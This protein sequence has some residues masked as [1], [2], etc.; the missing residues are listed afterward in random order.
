SFCGGGTRYYIDC[1]Q[2]CCGPAIGGGF[3]AGCTPCGCA[4]GCNTRRVYCNYFRYG[5]CHQEIALTGPIACRVVSCVP[6]Y[7]F[8][9]N[10]SSSAPAVDNATAEH[11]GNCPPPP[12]PPRVSLV[13]A[14]VTG[15]DN[16]LWWMRSTNG[17]WAGWAPLSGYLTSDVASVSD[18]SGVWVF[19]RGYD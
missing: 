19:V 16:Q 5:Q 10:A 17:N 4:N 7:A 14:F 3:C 9:E 6:P 18:A 1:M 2:Q 12:P 8:A 13:D 15:N 11:V